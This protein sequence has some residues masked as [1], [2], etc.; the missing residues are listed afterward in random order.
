MPT[1]QIIPVVTKSSIRR[2][3]KLAKEIWN[4]YYPPIIGQPQVDYMVKTF[5]SSKAIA[6]QIEEENFLY[7]LMQ[8]NNKEYIGYIGVVPK[9]STKELFLSKIY[10][11]KSSRGKGFGKKFVSFTK[12]LA[13]Q[14]SLN[15]ITLFV[16][17]DNYSSIAAYEKMGFKKVRPMKK[18]IGKGFFLDDYVMSLTVNKPRSLV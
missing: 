13:R 11:E 12:R 16:N 14:L 5:Q 8:R 15:K 3:E 1:I 9:K 10:I 6:M 17:K 2:V 4:E 7:Y 18:P